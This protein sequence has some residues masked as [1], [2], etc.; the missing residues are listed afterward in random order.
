VTA[1]LRPPR[2]GEA[3]GLPNIEATT[4]ENTRSRLFEPNTAD[5]ELRVEVAHRNGEVWIGES[6]GEYEVI[7]VADYQLVVTVERCPPGVVPSFSGVLIDYELAEE[8]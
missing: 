4:L 1:R 7:Q 3:D 2:F 6:G 5:G 8:A